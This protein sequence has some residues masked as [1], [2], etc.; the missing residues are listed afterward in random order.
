MASIYANENFPVRV[1][2]LLAARGHDVLTTHAARNSNKGIP[3]EEVLSFAVDQSRIVITLN[4]RDFKKL[5]RQTR[6]KHCGIIVCKDDKDRIGM[7][8][9]I[10]QHLP[11]E[12]CLDGKLVSI[13][14]Y[15][16]LPHLIATPGT[17]TVSDDKQEP[18]ISERSNYEGLPGECTGVSD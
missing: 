7:A 14:K 8:E 17:A 4:R 13:E 15:D 2:D 1:A 9:R 11:L 18:S 16:H 12:G 3:D 10:H 6:G 5:H